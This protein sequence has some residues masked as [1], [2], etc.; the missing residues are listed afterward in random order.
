MSLGWVA[1]CPLTEEENTP[2]A[3]HAAAVL[4]VG[5]HVRHPRAVPLNVNRDDSQPLARRATDSPRPDPVLDILNLRT[6]DQAP[7]TSPSVTINWP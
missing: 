3:G 5:D 6:L 7:V 1:A 4:I 2:H